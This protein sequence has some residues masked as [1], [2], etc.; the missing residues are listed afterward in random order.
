[1]K[2]FFIIS[3][4]AYITENDLLCEF[5]FLLI[6]F[7]QQLILSFSCYYYLSKAFSGSGSLC[8]NGDIRLVNGSSS[9]E[10]RIELCINEEWGT[11]CDDRFQIVD[12]I[13]VCRQLGFSDL[14]KQ[15]VH[16]V[17][18]TCKMSITIPSISVLQ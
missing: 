14:G 13:V 16:V 4:I 5:F 2:T 12:A 17:M 9:L 1:M 3:T 15:S 7:L 18:C 6:K 11:V 10:G 8:N